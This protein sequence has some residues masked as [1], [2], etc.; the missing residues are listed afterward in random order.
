MAD[1]D[2]VAS[3]LA[4]H[5]LQPLNSRIDCDL[6]HFAMSTTVAPDKIVAEY[7]VLWTNILVPLVNRDIYAV[8]TARAGGWDVQFIPVVVKVGK[9][10]LKDYFLLN[11]TKRVDAVDQNKS[12]PRIYKTPGFP[13]ARMGYE[14][15]VLR[16]DFPAW[17]IGRQHDALSQIVV[18]DELA[19]AI[20][21]RTKN[22]VSLILEVRS[23]TGKRVG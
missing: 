21:A 17:G 2:E 1:Y 18:G 6:L 3:G 19:A 9:A 4:R 15:M 10:F 7:G 5:D 20:T 8:I 16:S 22:G 14:R 23:A 13:D 11:P 12:I